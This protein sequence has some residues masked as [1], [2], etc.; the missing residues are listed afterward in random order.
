MHD[1]IK[2]I[3]PSPLMMELRMNIAARITDKIIHLIIR[4]SSDK[5]FQ[6]WKKKQHRLLNAHST[7]YRPNMTQQVTFD[8]KHNGNIFFFFKIATDRH[9]RLIF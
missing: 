3:N 7:C 9:Q 5:C 8:K 6:V 2:I 4:R 1:K